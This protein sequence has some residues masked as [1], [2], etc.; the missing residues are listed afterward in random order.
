MF[1]EPVRMLSVAIMA[2]WVCSSSV[3]A[4]DVVGRSVID[5]RPVELLDNGT[6]QFSDTARSGSRDSCIEFRGIIQFCNGS[7]DWSLL[8]T[9]SNA[10][11]AAEFRL[12]DRH[13]AML[14]PERVGRDDG[15]TDEAMRRVVLAN[16]ANFVGVPVE[17]IPVLDVFPSEVDGRAGETVVF[18][19]E[20][21]G[22]GV[23]YATSVFIG[24]DF[25]LQASTYGVAQGFTDAH[26]Q[27]HQEFLSS[28]RFSAK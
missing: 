14:I 6:W 17:Q 12:D 9:N 3:S 8:P 28:L 11:A 18:S 13:Y 5:G 2:T 1:I 15:L 16:A 20:I 23:V 25:N 19:A 21:D 10:E 4:Q 22:L 7:S 26:R 27:A 24:D